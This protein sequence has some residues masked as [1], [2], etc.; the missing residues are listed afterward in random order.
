MIKVKQ[1]KKLR[2]A[3]SNLTSCPFVKACMKV[4][5]SSKKRLIFGY[6]RGFNSFKINYKVISQL[7]TPQKIQRKEI[8]RLLA[9]LQD[10]KL[11]KPATLNPAVQCTFSLCLILSSTILLPAL[12]FFMFRKIH[13]AFILLIW[14]ISV[15]LFTLIFAV[16]TESSKKRVHEDLILRGE[17][18]NRILD[19]FNNDIFIDKY[20][21]RWSCDQFGSYLVL[22]MGALPSIVSSLE[23][24]TAAKTS[25]K[26]FNFVNE[27][28]E[29]TADEI[30]RNRMM[31]RK[32]FGEEFG[33]DPGSYLSSGF[34][35]KREIYEGKFDDSIDQDMRS[36]RVGTKNNAVHDIHQFRGERRYKYR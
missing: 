28:E 24:S 13:F 10:S 30:E 34:S 16:V 26:Q 6:D 3:L 20:G 35:E 1:P 25:K 7:E 9:A 27:T 12:F 32:Y 29:K 18:L 31:N 21:V 2:R 4:P 15:L 19:R 17:E 5:K 33:I 23:Q 36:A 11:W 22:S 14:V 8:K